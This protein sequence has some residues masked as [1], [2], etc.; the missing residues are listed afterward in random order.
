MK[1]REQGAG[2]A[3]PPGT[4]VWAPFGLCTERFRAAACSTEAYHLWTQ[5]SWSLSLMDA[6]GIQRSPKE[7]FLT[8]LDA[9]TRRSLMDPN[10]A[11]LADLDPR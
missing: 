11:F 2:K 10:G 6:A 1:R 5:M 8:L 4:S 7:K 3:G 9:G